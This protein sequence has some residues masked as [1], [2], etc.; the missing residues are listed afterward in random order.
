LD[1][2]IRAKISFEDEY[3]ATIP[4]DLGIVKQYQYWFEQLGEQTY[5]ADDPWVKFY[6]TFFNDLRKFKY[7]GTFRLSYS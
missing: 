6:L 4:I 1:E 2:I 3:K 7:A 5:A